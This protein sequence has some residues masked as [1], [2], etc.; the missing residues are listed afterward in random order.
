MTPQRIIEYVIYGVLFCFA[1]YCGV[2]WWTMSN[3]VDEMQKQYAD[4]S[5][6]YDASQQRIG[7][8]EQSVSTQNAAV[9]ALEAEKSEA[10]KRSDAAWAT[11]AALTGRIDGLSKALAGKKAQTCAEAMPYI[12]AA[13]QGAK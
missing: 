6:K 8:L 7:R 9:T 10:N 2:N 13:L 4:L 11:A 12:R 1:V 5:A 3:K